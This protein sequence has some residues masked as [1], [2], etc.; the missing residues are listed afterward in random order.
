MHVNEK[1]FSESLTSHF[2]EAIFAAEN[3]T[4]KNRDINIAPANTIMMGMMWMMIS[5]NTKGEAI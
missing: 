4:M 1:Y 3:R 2:S 5:L